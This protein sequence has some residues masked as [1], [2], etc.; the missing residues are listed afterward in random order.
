MCYDGSLNHLEEMP[1]ELW[2][3]TNNFGDK[4]HVLLYRANPEDY[5]GQMPSLERLLQ[6]LAESREKY[7]DKIVAA[8]KGKNGTDAE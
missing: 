5:L 4:F 6:V 3:A 2:L 7:R 8:R 1:Y